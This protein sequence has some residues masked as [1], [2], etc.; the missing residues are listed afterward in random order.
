ILGHRHPVRD[1]QLSAD[2]LRNCHHA[3]V[4]DRHV[5][6]R[7]HGIARKSL[8]RILPTFDFGSASR[9]RTSLATLYGASSRRQCAIPSL[10]VSLAPRVCAPNS[11]TASPVFSS[12]RPTQAHSATPVQAAA[13]ASTS[14][15]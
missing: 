13:T 5:R 4:E 10:S 15:G 14:F 2:E 12:A 1:S 6:C 9:K 11:L 3:V 7:L 8:R